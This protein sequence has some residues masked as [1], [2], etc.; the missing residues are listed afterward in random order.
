MPKYKATFVRNYTIQ[1]GFEREIEAE[2]REA[3]Y[4]LAEAI[5]AE[6]DEN[7]PDDVSET[8]DDGG[9]TPFDMQSLVLR[10]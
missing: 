7:M 4:Q 3:A 1:E 10:P 8:G 6:A 9:T 5:A 2:N